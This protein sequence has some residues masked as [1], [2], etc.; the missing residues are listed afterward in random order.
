MN[1]DN[2]YPYENSADAPLPYDGMRVEVFD[3]RDNPLFEAVVKTINPRLIMLERTS[4]L[5]SGDIQDA[6]RVSVRGFHFRQNCG[7]LMEGRLVKLAQVQ[8]KAWMVADLTVVGTDSGRTFSRSRIQ[9]KAWIAP[10]NDTGGTWAECAVNDASAGGVR[11]QTAVLLTMGAR[12]WIRFKLRRGRDQPPLL[13]AVRRITEREEGY[14]YGCE[15][16]DI[17]PE[18]DSVIV[19][20]IIELNIMQK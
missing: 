19:K 2:R 7:V 8:D 11:F 1:E 15:F 12:Y 13:C 16:V 14:E 3:N 9:A 18:V 10:E 17:T 4:E 5:T 20:T 6:M